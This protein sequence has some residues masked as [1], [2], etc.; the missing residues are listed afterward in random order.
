[1][2]EQNARLKILWIARTCPFPAN[3]GEKL[4]VFNLLKA[5]AQRHDLTVVYRVI[6]AEEEAGA[7][8]LRKFCKGVH[9]VR[10]PRPRGI[11]EK[12]RWMLPFLFSRYPLA[13]CTVFFK[14]IVRQL[15]RLAC[16][17]RYDVVQV[18]HSSLSIYRDHVHFTDDPAT[19]LT[20][21]NIDYVRNERVLRNTPWGAAKLYHWLNQR[22]FK[23]WELSVLKQYDQ[24]IA[25]SGVDRQM[26]QAD[27]PGLPVQVVPNGVDAQAIPFAPAVGNTSNVI[28]VA[29]MD[30][31]ANHDGA[32]FFLREVWPL[33]K[34]HQPGAVLKFVGRSPNPELRAADNGKSSSWS[35][36]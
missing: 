1:M 29:S 30:S 16:S 18:E 21:H 7:V 17:E 4:R 19:V 36:F 23:Q 9:G 13:L 22:R 8:E 35:L 25:M 20:M 28:F 12:L 11:A 15:E 2:Q 27:V 14:P 34:R 26:L 5:L 3:D 31:E 6:E 32:M 24:V 33:L 10:V